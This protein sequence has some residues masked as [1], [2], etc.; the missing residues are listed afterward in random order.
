MT[1]STTW[2]PDVHPRPGSWAHFEFL[3]AFYL[4]VCT[5]GN[6]NSDQSQFQFL[7]AFFRKIKKAE[8]E[9]RLV[10]VPVLVRLLLGL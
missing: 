8:L 9:L 1:L 7:Y 10:T 5:K 2:I 6:S 3:H 4:A